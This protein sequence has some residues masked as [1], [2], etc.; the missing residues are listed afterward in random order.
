MVLVLEALTKLI[1]GVELLRSYRVAHARVQSI[2]PFENALRECTPLTSISDP[3]GLSEYLNQVNLKGDMVLDELKK[4]SNER[5]NLRTRLTE[6]ESSAKQAWDELSSLKQGMETRSPQPVHEKPA[7]IVQSGARPFNP[8]SED[9]AAFTTKSDPEPVPGASE[10]APASNSR[11]QQEGEDFF[12]FDDEIPRLQAALRERQG[13]IDTLT[14]EVKNLRGDLVVTREST[15]SMVESLEEATRELS[16]LR[17]FKDRADD[18]AKKQQSVSEKNMVGSKTQLQAA[19]GYPYNDSIESTGISIDDLQS[20]L[21]EAHKQ[22]AMLRQQ[23]TPDPDLAKTE[24]PQSALHESEASTTSLQE[25]K[26]RTCRRTET[27]E[28]L[29]V[30]LRSQLEQMEEREKEARTALERHLSNQRQSDVPNGRPEDFVK[31][32][33]AAV[34]NKKK[35]QKKRKGQSIQS[36]QVPPDMATAPAEG[37]KREIPGIASNATHV[38]KLQAELSELRKVVKAK[39]ATIDH[40]N[41]KL[42]DQDD[43]KEEIESLRDDL[44]NVGQEHVSAKDQIKDLAA[45]KLKLNASIAELEAALSETQSLQ[46]TTTEAPQKQQNDL[47]NQFDDLKVKATALQTDLS[48]A[49]QLA[50]ARF[51]DISEMKTMVQKAQSELASLRSE[52]AK[53]MPLQNEI[54]KKDAEVKALQSKQS[55]LYS[56]IDDVKSIL[57]RRNMEIKALNQRMG[58]EVTSRLRA[59]ELQE[60]G[61]QSL[62]MLKKEHAE[63]SESFRRITKDLIKAQKEI[64]AAKAQVGEFEQQISQHD[65][66]KEVLREE[67]D[68]KSAQYASAQS[69][70]SSMRDQTSEMA[71]Q[72]KEARDK[73]ESLEEEV[74]GAHR[75]LGERSR[76]AETMRRLLADVEG[77]AD[78]R[79]R[80]MKE[81]MEI[82][83]EERDRA[84]DEASTTGR[85][86]AR[87]SEELRSKL[88]ET[89]RMLKRA[90]EDKEELELAQRDWKRR[91]EDLEEQSERSM[92]ETNEVR[93]AM[94][95]LRDVLDGAERQTR[96]LEKQKSEL[97]RSVEE[98]QRRL[99]KL[100]KSNKV[101]TFTPNGMDW[102]F[103]KPTQTM[104]DEIQIMRN[105]KSKRVDTPTPSSRSSI[106]SAPPRRSLASPPTAAR[107]NSESTTETVQ[108]KTAGSMDYLYL[109]NVLLQF[110]EQ[111]DKKHQMQLIPVLGMLLHFDRSVSIALCVRNRWAKS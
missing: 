86:K 94:A 89:E 88:R 107:T 52:A 41:E 13:T 1:R 50:S 48:A 5:D 83:L 47:Q 46:S 24:K 110:L 109:K 84:E 44:I 8:T 28:K 27:L 105:T 99:E 92:A 9:S 58:H 66:E 55:S 61:D 72:L 37:A 40:L 78:A 104:I 56:E 11:I 75:L 80:E 57:T 51:K 23:A 71:M 108:G 60:K 30:S 25:E 53:L 19:E 103:A 73:C 69:L 35:K 95:E 96:D 26:L 16:V 2:E 93:R 100:Q 102:S 101:S 7:Q 29:V 111:K 22:L 18:E 77:R 54:E 98:T 68:L 20:R 33:E 63:T 67:M 42:K 87:E 31:P 10:A 39:D 34:G 70:M 38:E 49:Q 12:S 6:A 3:G 14:N 85:R 81:R 79:T 82:A 21:S 15:Q 62:E 32:L 90:E 36:V 106:D 64:E 76:E 17:E 45:E 43:M 59:E 91:R 65:R 97:Q 74:G 4:V